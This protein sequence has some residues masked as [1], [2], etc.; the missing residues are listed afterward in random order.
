MQNIVVKLL[1]CT[2]L[3]AYHSSYCVIFILLEVFSCWCFFFKHFKMIFIFTMHFQ[4]WYVSSHS[5]QEVG[6]KT[7]R[8]PHLGKQWTN[9]VSWLFWPFPAKS[10]VFS[11]T[12]WKKRQNNS[13]HDQTDRRTCIDWKRDDT[14]GESSKSPH[15][16]GGLQTLV[17]GHQSRYLCLGAQRKKLNQ[18][19]K[20]SFFFKHKHLQL[21]FHKGKDNQCDI[22]GL[23]VD[24]W[25]YKK[26]T[27]G[28]AKER[29]T[30]KL[31]RCPK[32]L[33]S[34]WDLYSQQ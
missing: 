24:F 13:A 12:L 30:P 10:I 8:Q 21:K 31:D 11:Q 14:T 17:W 5:I 7:F 20:I 28:A 33:T 34:I 27:P 18:N 15:L 19:A 6:T 3:L 16:V 32:I 22:T 26:V 23:I 2:H 1:N 9:T 4:R 29:K 25:T